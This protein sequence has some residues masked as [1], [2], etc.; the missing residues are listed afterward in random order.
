MPNITSRIVEICVFKIVDGDPL[1]L[2]LKRTQTDELYPGI[3]QIVTGVVEEGEHTVQAALRELEEETGLHPV[4]FWRLPFVNS[5]FEPR[6]DVVHLCPY[7]AARVVSSAEPV[8]SS[9]HQRYEWCSLDR[10]QT[11]LPWSGQ[12]NGVRIAHNQCVQETEESRL[13]EIDYQKRKNF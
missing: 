13:L 11:L 5:F 4:K 6:R 1:Y 2:I 8:L 3:W 9:E 12:R 7:F 10:A